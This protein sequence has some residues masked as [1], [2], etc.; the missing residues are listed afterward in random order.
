MNVLMLSGGIEST[1]IAF[2]KRPHVC[3]TVDYG[4]ICAR[5]E[6]EISRAI[7]RELRLEHR[8]IEAP[9]KSFGY[10]LLGGK[11]AANPDREEFWP[12]R[13]QF[14]ATVAA[15]V[16]YH[17]RIKEIW[18]GVV[19]SDGRFRDSSNEFFRTLDSLVSAQEGNIR[20]K[21]PAKNISTETLIKSSGIS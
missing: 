21:A 4:Q 16:L 3:V 7:T 20:I 10:G 8:V 15:M 11:D 12:F 6:I 5:T 9:I 14:L 19:R 18:F 2:W 1:C 17:E 13:N